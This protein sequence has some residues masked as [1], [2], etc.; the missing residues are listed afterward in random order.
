M[1]P[2][3]QGLKLGHPYCWW[4]RS[5][6]SLSSGSRKTRIETKEADDSNQPVLRLSSV[7]EKQGL[8]LRKE[9]PSG[10]SSSCL[11]MGSRKT[12]IETSTLLGANAGYITSK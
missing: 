8:K 5:I 2:E 3:K 7:P 4:E 10:F 9:E 6:A 1:V 11:S 12:R